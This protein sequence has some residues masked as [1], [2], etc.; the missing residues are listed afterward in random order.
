MRA[1]L[2]RLYASCLLSSTLCTSGGWSGDMDNVLKQNTCR[3]YVW[4]LTVFLCF[5][6][7]ERESPCQ[8]EAA[9]PSSLCFST[10]FTTGVAAA[11][12]LIVLRR[13]LP[14]DVPH[15]RSSTRVTC[16]SAMCG[17]RVSSQRAMMRLLFF[18]TRNSFYQEQVH[19][20]DD[21]REVDVLHLGCD[22]IRC[23]VRWNC[24]STHDGQQL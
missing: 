12:N 10:C 21:I 6:V 14:L 24:S 2:G 13:R 1:Q 23:L 22:S 16:H 4:V 20:C 18:A 5:A 15:K 11:T 9:P 17:R 7:H 8:A 19:T 3:T